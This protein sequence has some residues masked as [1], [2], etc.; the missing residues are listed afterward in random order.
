MLVLMT[1]EYFALRQAAL[2]LM[3]CREVTCTTL[4]PLP[5]F[6]AGCTLVATEERFSAGA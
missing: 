2:C 3:Y 5:C 1:E 6:L 4:A